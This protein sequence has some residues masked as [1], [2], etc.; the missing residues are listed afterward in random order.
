MRGEGG[1]ARLSE[2]KE[3]KGKRWLQ[4]E[5]QDVGG[6]GRTDTL[7]PV[8]QNGSDRAGLEGA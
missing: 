6:H 4:Q 3:E 7:C 5:E 2:G 8:P 1:E